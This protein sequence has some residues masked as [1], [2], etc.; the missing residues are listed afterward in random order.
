MYSMSS[1]FFVVCFWASQVFIFVDETPTGQKPFL[2]REFLLVRYSS[3]PFRSHL[4][5]G[6]TGFPTMGHGCCCLRW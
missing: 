5:C 2:L 4:L 3:W 1:I 6:F